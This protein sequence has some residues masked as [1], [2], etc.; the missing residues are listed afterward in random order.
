VL[1]LV[2][3]EE[4]WL[5]VFRFRVAKS[6]SPQLLLS[7]LLTNLLFGFGVKEGTEGL[8]RP[9]KERK[10]CRNCIVENVNLSNCG[11]RTEEGKMNN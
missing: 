3:K 11:T 5:Y 6:K 10:S 4:C 1:E 9:R 7:W 8:A 2:Q